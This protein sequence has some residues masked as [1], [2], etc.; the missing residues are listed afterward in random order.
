MV[1]TGSADAENGEELLSSP[2]AGLA[3]K[4]AMWA[5]SGPLLPLC[6]FFLTHPGNRGRKDLRCPFGCRQTWQRAQSTSRSQAYRCTEEG[7]MKKRKLN[8]RRYRQGEEPSPREAKSAELPDETM[9]EHIR[10]VVSMIEG[11]RITTAEARTLIKQ[12]MEKR[13]PTPP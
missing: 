8:Q 10:E 13:E 11:R 5:V 12:R 2:A 1:A 3:G 6:Y 7:A 9:V 4:F